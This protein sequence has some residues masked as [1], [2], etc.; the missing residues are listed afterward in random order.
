M[1]VEK[2][3][4]PIGDLKTYPSNPNQG[5]IGAIS[6]SIK[7]FGQFRSIVVNKRTME[8]LAGNHTYKAME[9]LGHKEIEVDFVDVDEMT[10]K[11]IVLADN[12]LSDISLYDDNALKDLLEEIATDDDLAGTGFDNDDLD[13]LIAELDTPLSL[14]INQAPDTDTPQFK[15]ELPIDLIF[16]FAPQV[17][18]SFVA[19]EFGWLS[20]VISKDSVRYVDSP[21][22]EEYL[23][24]WAWHH[25]IEFID[26]EWKGYDH[27]KHI[28]AVEFFKPKYATTRDI[29]SSDQCRENKVEYLTF[30]KIMEYAEEVDKHATHTIVIPKY[31]CIDKIPE[32][33]VL[34]FSV[35]TSYGGTE[36]HHEKFKGRPIHLLGGSWKLQLKY[37]EYFGDD[38]ISLDTNYIFLLA[39]YGSYVK[40]NGDITSLDK[41]LGYPIGSVKSHAT[42]ATTLS[43]TNITKRVQEMCGEVK[44]TE[45]E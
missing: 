5:D 44:T 23:S 28:R 43:F 7:Q 14:S 40:E 20:G 6:E 21:K 41:E 8:I 37:L 39:E 33:Y 35:P 15:R 24:R 12:R 36:V 9:S 11:K 25:K 42:L 10:A 13:A 26:N 3:K 38:V 18:M 19:K 31:D 2:K 4:V 17:T 22:A 30:D 27:D 32:K 16:S 45:E 1:I 34:G 29:M